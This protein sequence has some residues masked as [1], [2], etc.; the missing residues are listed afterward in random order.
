[1]IKLREAVNL[2]LKS[3]HPRV[4]YQEASTQLAYPYITYSLLDSFTV[5]DIEVFHLDLDIWDNRDD[6]TEMEQIATILWN[7][8]DQYTH[9]DENQHFTICR[10]TR[11]PIRDVKIKRRRLVFQLRYTDRTM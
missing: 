10:M 3:I 4:R 5:D 6:T 7:E 1:M 9:I 8:L 11:N 2:I